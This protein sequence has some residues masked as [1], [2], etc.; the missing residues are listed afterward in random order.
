MLAR[1]SVISLKEWSYMLHLDCHHKF[2]EACSAISAL[3][4][5]HVENVR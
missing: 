5:G 3:Y 2:T 4:I 1:Y